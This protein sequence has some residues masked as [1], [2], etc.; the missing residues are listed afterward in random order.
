MSE[1]IWEHDHTD[2]W[3]FVVD[4]TE[5]SLHCNYDVNHN[6]IIS[7]EMLDRLLKGAG[8]YKYEEG[9]KSV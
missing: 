9:I 4:E 3:R 6:A 2:E 5:Y 1:Y 7:K 8:A